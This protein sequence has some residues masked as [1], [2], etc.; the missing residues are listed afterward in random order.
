M[1]GL[2]DVQRHLLDTESDYILYECKIEK[3]FFLCVKFNENFNNN[4]WAGRS[5]VGI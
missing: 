3:R 2:L 4:A 5:A 1:S